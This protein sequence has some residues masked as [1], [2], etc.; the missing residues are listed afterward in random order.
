MKRISSSIVLWPI[1]HFRT[2]WVIILE[3]EVG[4]VIYCGPFFFFLLYNSSVCLLLFLFV[5]FLF[6]LFSI[7]H[8]SRL[9]C[10]RQHAH[11]YN[12]AL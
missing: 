11:V 6:C 9:L 12:N 5:L 10:I 8:I 4:G 7:K 2:R 3:S 1:E